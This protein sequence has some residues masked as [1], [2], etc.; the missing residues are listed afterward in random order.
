[1]AVVYVCRF[2]GTPRK[3]PFRTRKRRCRAGINR[4]RDA[5]HRAAAEIDS[6]PPSYRSSLSHAVLIS[7]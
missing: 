6:I 2:V 3:R 1:M 4:G 5:P 7:T